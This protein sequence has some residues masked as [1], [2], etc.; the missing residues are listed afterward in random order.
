MKS[1][2]SVAI[3]VL[4]CLVSISSAD[5]DMTSWLNNPSFDEPDLGEGGI[6]FGADGWLD[7]VEDG[8]VPITYDPQFPDSASDGDNFLSINYF[9]SGVY[10]RVAGAIFQDSTT[11]TMTAD[12]LIP[13]T[14][15]AGWDPNEAWFYMTIQSQ[16]EGDLGFFGAVA[17]TDSLS[18]YST[19]TWYT[20][21]CQFDSS[22]D[23]TRVGEGLQVLCWGSNIYLDN[24]TLTATGTEVDLTVTTDASNPDAVRMPTVGVLKAGDGWIIPIDANTQFSDTPDLNTFTGWAVTGGSV[25]DIN[26]NLA[27]LTISGNTTLDA[28]FTITQPG[29]SQAWENFLYNPQFVLNGSFENPALAEG[30]YESTVPDN[31]LWQF[32]EGG[33]RINA[34]N[35]GD[36]THYIAANNISGVHLYQPTAGTVENYNTYKLR[37]DILI[38]SFLGTGWDP[39]T[40]WVY[41]ALQT[42]DGGELGQFGGWPTHVPMDEYERDVWH[43]V[44]VEWDSTTEPSRVG[45][46]FQVQAFG[47]NIYL[48]NVRIIVAEHRFPVSVTMATNTTGLDNISP[49]L[50]TVDYPMNA[51]LGIEA[52]KFDILCPNG[53]GFDSWTGE[54]VYD[55]TENSTGVVLDDDMTITANYVLDGRQYDGC[56]EFCNPFLDMDLNYDCAVTLEDFSAIANDWPVAPGDAVEVLNGSFEDPV[57]G[58]RSKYADD[59]PGWVIDS[60]VQNPDIKNQGF[61]TDGRNHIVVNFF[62]TSFYQQIADVFEADTT[63]R[64]MADILIPERIDPAGW[65]PTAAAWTIQIQTTNPAIPPLAIKSGTTAADP[66]IE[67]EQWY[68]VSCDFD[69]ST[70]A[71]RVGEGIQIGVICGNVRI[72]NVR[73]VKMQEPSL[74]YLA[75]FASQWLD[76]NP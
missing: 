33:L 54:R 29:T 36:G 49:E 53:Y 44:E 9:N 24:I 51:V 38:P 73:L 68:T 10:Q 70:D 43:T 63:Y 15:G 22:T 69:S 4:L 45:E 74:D 62:G 17:D 28:S 16:E 40:A 71:A 39:D 26:S 6:Y 64:L 57:I 60:I 14:L 20:V 46:N 50:G 30:A 47:G 65:D 61:A 11:Y 13:T 34:G 32:G 27:E 23:I 48:D 58:V 7:V 52:Y 18:G 19:D 12:I 3:L 67:Y 8:S 35:A 31:W 25:D 56:G 59:L 76:V 37:A 66:T 1:Y 5:V 21:S 55:A 75:A 2:R 42:T 72:D 41:L